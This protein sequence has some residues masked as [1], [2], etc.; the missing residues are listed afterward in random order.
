MKLAEGWQQ[1]FK[2]W[3][4]PL[5]KDPPPRL[6][7]PPKFARSSNYSAEI[8]KLRTDLTEARQQNH[9]LSESN[10]RLYAQLQKLQAQLA[11]QETGR[12]IIGMKTVR[13]LSLARG[14]TGSTAA[15][16]SGPR[17]SMITR[18]QGP[19][20]LPIVTTATALAAGQQEV[21][22]AEAT[23]KQAEEDCD[24]DLSKV[25]MMLSMHSEGQENL[26]K[27]SALQ[28]ASRIPLLKVTPPEPSRSPLSD[29]TNRSP[30]SA[31]NASAGS[32]R[33]SSA[34]PRATLGL[35]ASPR[36]SIRAVS[37]VKLYPCHQADR[38]V[39]SHVEIGRLVSLVEPQSIALILSLVQ[40]LLLSWS[41]CISHVSLEVV[42]SIY[43]YHSPLPY[44]RCELISPDIAA[45]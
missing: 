28:V 40:P 42:L 30:R 27:T 38:R 32:K 21:K 23:G 22:Q 35:S 33:R 10:K 13:G 2:R 6:P 19:A 12:S 25:S 29:A 20:V 34:S 41:P 37:P 44:P 17:R 11:R 14:S 24:G 39:A 16:G 36:S 9:E 5:D 3:H 7:S 45:V 15:S 31:P 4:V 1:R 8:E 26:E 18:S 43:L